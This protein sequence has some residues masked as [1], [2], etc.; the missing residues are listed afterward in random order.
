MTAINA[1]LIK[2]LPKT[3]DLSS[4]FYSLLSI[5]T[6]LLIFRNWLLHFGIP[7]ALPY[8]LEQQITNTK[9]ETK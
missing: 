2:I 6:Y 1:H 4:K 7:D 9:K 3:K 5:A 8:T